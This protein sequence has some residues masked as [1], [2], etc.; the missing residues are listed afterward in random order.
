MA[1]GGLFVLALVGAVVMLFR[2]GGTGSGSDLLAAGVLGVSAGLLWWALLAAAR[3]S[4]H[5]APG[6][7]EVH[8]PSRAV[9]VADPPGGP[10]R[11]RRGA[12]VGSIPEQRPAAG[13]Q[14]ADPLPADGAGGA[15][16][17]HAADVGRPADA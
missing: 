10:H 4:R 6:G 11:P 5:H 17:G 15:H 13:A 16:G 8:D 2:A 3:P 7:G 14:E 9:A 1:I 12:A